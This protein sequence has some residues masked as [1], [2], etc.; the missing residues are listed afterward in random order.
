MSSFLADQAHRQRIVLLMWIAI[1]SVLLW[2]IEIGSLLLYPFT[3][4]ATWFHEMGHGVAAMLTG[5]SF[6]RLLIFPDGSGVAQSMVPANASGLTHAVIA[7]SGPLG[8]AIAGSLLIIASRTEKATRAALAIV[9]LA[10]IITTVIWV[11]TFTG[12]LVLPALGT[13]ILALAWRGSAD[14]R[15]FGIQLLGVQACISVWQQ[16]GFLFSAG[17]SVGGELHRSDTSAIADALLLPYWFWG[18]AISVVIVLM[19]WSSFAIAF[20]R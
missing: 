1:G 3:I 19:V 6:E 20:R 4:L 11:R 13:A 9:G 7:A 15:H 5:S 16:F 17:G 10:L 2:Q 14:Q 8:P 12:W 18:A